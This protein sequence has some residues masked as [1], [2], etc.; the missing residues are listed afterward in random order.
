MKRLLTLLSVAALTTLFACSKNDNPQTKD[1]SI[2]KDNYTFVRSVQT[3]SEAKTQRS[4]TYSDPFEITKVERTGDIVKVT[5][6]FIKTCENTKEEF[7]VIWDGQVNLSY[8]PMI[9]MFLKRKAGDCTS[10][11]TTVT[12]VLTVNLKD[13]IDSQSTINESI[14]VIANASKLK[15]D[16]GSDVISTPTNQ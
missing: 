8:P 3:A 12:E 4:S 13:L 16:T 9:T 11:G 10:T 14:I 15:T 1:E 2:K 5:V 7:S 6:S